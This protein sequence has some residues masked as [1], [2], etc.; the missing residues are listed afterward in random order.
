MSY[1]EFRSIPITFEAPM[2]LEKTGKIYFKGGKVYINELFKGIHVIDN[3]NPSAPS[4]IGF[5]SIPGNVDIAIKG[6]ILYADSY[7]DLLALDISTLSNISIT[8]RLEDV[9]EPSLPPFDETFP[10]APLDHDNGVVT[11]WK[12]EKITEKMDVTG[13]YYFGGGRLVMFDAFAG[14]TGEKTTTYFVPNA[15]GIAGSMARFIIYTDY[16]YTINDQDIHVFNISN[17]P[18]PMMGASVETVRVIETLFVYD[19]NLFVGST[20]GMLI[21]SLGNPSNPS[22]LSALDHFRSCDPVVVEGDYA[23]VTLRAGSGCNN[24]TS[25]QL[26][27]VNISNITNPSLLKSFALTGPYGLGI[28]NDV[29]FICDGDDGLKVFD[30][31]DKENIDKNLIKHFPGI[32]AFDIIPFNDVAMMIGEDGLYQYSYSDLNNLE[33]LSVIP[34]VK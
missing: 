9:F 1:D 24:N 7:I 13:N 18:A 28:D 23:Y 20:T 12:I 10:I 29:L 2:P 22:Y 16:L 17:T 26:D 14:G 21:Y 32:H 11:G 25:N 15:V 6:N 3:S 33:L 8:K 34:I 5:I 19:G 30:A 31:T 27:V 4:N